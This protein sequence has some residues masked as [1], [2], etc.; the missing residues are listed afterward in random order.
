VIVSMREID[1]VLIFD[2]EGDFC[3]SDNKGTSLPELVKA[4]LDRGRKKMLVNLEKS[5]F[6]DSIGVGEILESLVAVRNAGGQLKI[7][8]S[9]FYQIPDPD[10]ELV[11]RNVEDALS[12]FRPDQS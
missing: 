10:P 9:K 1:N 6:I 8:Y 12:H 7:A 11:Y 3:L 2:I 4:Y 5:G